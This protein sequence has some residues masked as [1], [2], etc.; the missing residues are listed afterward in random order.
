MTPNKLNQFMF[1]YAIA[2]ARTLGMVVGM[3]FLC[4]ECVLN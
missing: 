4:L 3:L 1:V 2:A